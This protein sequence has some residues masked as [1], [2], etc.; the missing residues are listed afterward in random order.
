MIDLLQKA[1]QLIL[2]RGEVK[3]LRDR[4]KER[5]E[6]FTIAMRAASAAEREGR[7]AEAI[8]NLE[9]AEQA[10]P[11]KYRAE[12]LATLADS[13]S[14]RVEIEER[15]N[16]GTAALDQ[17]R[18]R[19]AVENYDL[20]LRADPENMTAKKL[21]SRALFLQLLARGDE[22]AS[23]RSFPDALEAFELARIQ[24]G[25]QGPEVYERMQR[26]LPE[27]RAGGSPI[28][29][30]WMGVMRDSDPQRFAKARPGVAA[31]RRPD[32]PIERPAVHDEANVRRTVLAAVAAEPHEALQLLKKVSA[33]QKGG[34]AEL[35]SWT[36]V[37][38]ARL[39]FLTADP[40]LKEE[41]R[42][43]ATQHF[44][45]ALDLDPR[46]RLDSRLVPPRILELFAAARR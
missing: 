29:N 1:D 9:Q 22:L 10:H 39:S 8:A 45:R 14:R 5:E 7:I 27:L 15:L 21:R 44:R 32:P 18:F 28:R 20:V 13:L 25:G 31:R 41:F 23:A 17:G 4:V 38:Y 42:A 12:K 40:K 11:E 46:H 3:A 33:D 2:N 16:A 24:D 19:Q 34:N 37:A 43:Q 35:E 26:Y 36:G 6:K 30:D